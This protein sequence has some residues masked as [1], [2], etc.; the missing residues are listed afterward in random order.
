MRVVQKPANAK[1]SLINSDPHIR[2][3]L[4]QTEL[5]LKNWVGD[6][7]CVSYKWNYKSFS[8]NFTI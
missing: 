2:N 6:R 5:T 8:S 4:S 1:Q 7:K 3:P